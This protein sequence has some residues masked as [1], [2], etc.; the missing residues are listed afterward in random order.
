VTGRG[1]GDEPGPLFAG[2]VPPAF[3]RHVWIVPAGASR[4]VGDGAWRDA[5]VEVEQ[6]EIELRF[7]GGRRLRFGH[8]DVL[9]M[10]GLPPGVLRSRGPQPAVLVAVRRRAR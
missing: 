9:W 4:P 6:G 10:H 8:G 7:R 1:A 3:E 2:I 5:L